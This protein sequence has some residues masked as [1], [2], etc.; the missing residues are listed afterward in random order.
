ML[1]AT[2]PTPEFIKSA[3]PETTSL[4]SDF[5]RITI[6]SVVTFLETFTGYNPWIPSGESEI[7]LY[8]IGD[9]SRGGYYLDVHNGLREAT[10]VKV[11]G[12]TKTEGT[13]YILASMSDDLFYPYDFVKFLSS[14]PGPDDEITIKANWGWGQVPADLYLAVA[15]CSAQLATGTTAGNLKSR[16]QGPIEKEYFDNSIQ[17]IRRLLGN[18]LMKYR[19]IV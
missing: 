4:D 7:T 8:G 19:R 16:K 3:F 18:V 5:L 15:S 1:I 10:Y 13:D 6:G 9:I 12:V 17:D 14:Y 11:N 2:F